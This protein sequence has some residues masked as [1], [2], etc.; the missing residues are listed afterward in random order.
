MMSVNPGFGGQKFIKRTTD[1][2][3]RLR[4]LCDST[5]GA[6][7]VAIQIDGGITV[8]TAPEVVEAGA[9]IL[10]AGSAVFGKE[11]R[12]AAITALRAASS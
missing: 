2:V 3:R 9:R 12:A 7:H 11:D 10:V 5:P 8:D 6:E 1:K 4:A